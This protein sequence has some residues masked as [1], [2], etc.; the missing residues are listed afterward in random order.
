MNIDRKTVLYAS[1]VAFLLI[2]PFLTPYTALASNVLIFMLFAMA[3]DICLGY[4]GML[5]FGHAAFF[6][7]GAY[8]TA[9]LILHLKANVFLAIGAGMLLSLIISYPIG[10]LAIRRRGIYFAMVTLAFAQMLYFIAFKW[11]SLTGGDDGLQGVP[12]PDLFGLSLQSEIRIYYVILGFLILAIMFATRFVGSPFGKALVSIREN[13]QRAMS[14]GFNPARFKLVAFIIS[15]TLS[16]LAGSLYCLL[17][18]FVPLNSLHWPL[19]GE[20]VMMTILGGM[21]TLIGP[22]VGGMFIVLVREVLSTYTRLWAL[23]MGVSFVVIIMAF[24]RGIVGELK[25]RIRL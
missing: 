21:G 18:N 12:R 6:G 7:V 3:Y 16:G 22:L 5:S 1:G 23:F 11:V 13:E 4:A 14:I 24:R 2:F 9:L 15:A 19:S 17:Q 20:I 10:F 8:T 25:K